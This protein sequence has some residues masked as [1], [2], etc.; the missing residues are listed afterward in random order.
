[1][2]ILSNPTFQTILGAFL[3]AF[4]GWLFSLT[5]SSPVSENSN[6]TVIEVKNII[7]QKIIN[8]SSN[9]KNEGDESAWVVIL[10]AI[11]GFSIY[12]YVKYASHIF[13]YI[14]IYNISLFSFIVTIT[15]IGVFNKQINSNE[16]LTRILF[17]IVFFGATI[18]SFHFLE[19]NI[20]SE[21][22]QYANKHEL[23]DFFLNL[24]RVGLLFISYQVFSFVLIVMVSLLSFLNFLNYFSLMNLRGNKKAKLWFLLYKHTRFSSGILY[25]VLTIMFLLLMFVIQTEWFT[26]KILNK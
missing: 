7:N 23:I 5:S 14:L 9:K 15:F 13:S 3:G 6:L 4:L 18:Y 21:L 8:T 26:E 16:W 12:F 25:Y 24:T 1:M 17:P 11:L 20:N 22:I 2:E 19:K 10:F